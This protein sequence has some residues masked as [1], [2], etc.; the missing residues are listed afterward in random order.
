[1][2]QD[3][4]AI[5]TN[6]DIE[7]ISSIG[8]VS[9]YHSAVATFFAPGDTSSTRGMRCELI[10]STPSWRGGAP[11]RDCAFIVEDEEQAGM[12]GMALVRVLLFF[13]VEYNGV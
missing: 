6:S 9:V 4:L 1:M 11:R 5:Q 3:C 10:H 13:S 8:A 2:V 7:D 12:S